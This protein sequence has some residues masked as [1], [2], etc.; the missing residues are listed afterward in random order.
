V[1][2]SLLFAGATVSDEPAPPVFV[3]A[4]LTVTPLR[5]SAFAAI[6]SFLQDFPWAPRGVGPRGFSSCVRDRTTR[7]LHGRSRYRATSHRKLHDSG[8]R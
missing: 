4:G 6:S 1:S 2:R 7:I 5:R 8:V 3:D